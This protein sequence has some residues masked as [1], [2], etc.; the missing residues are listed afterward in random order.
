[1]CYR[2]FLREKKG[3]R[4]NEK[5]LSYCRA[6]HAEQ[7]AIVM[8]SKPLE[9]GTLYVTTFPCNDCAKMIS[10]SGIRK[11]VYIHPYPMEEA[12]NLLNERGIMM[13]KFEGVK[14]KGYYKLF[15]EG[16]RIHI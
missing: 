3:Y 4:E 16:K 1:M 7:N 10:K 8:S 11:V 12:M 9:G 6:L 14:A 2:H 13:E 15:A 5:L